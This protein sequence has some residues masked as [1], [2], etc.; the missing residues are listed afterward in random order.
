MWAAFL[1]KAQRAV[2]RASLHTGKSNPGVNVGKAAA[3]LRKR[4]EVA[5]HAGVY[6]PHKQARTD[7]GL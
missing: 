1:P 3:R 7:S 4:G 5:C 2:S 6:V